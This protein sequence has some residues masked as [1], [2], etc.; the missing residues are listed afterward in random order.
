MASKVIMDQWQKR[1]ISSEQAK[2]DLIR[3]RCRGA[4]NSLALIEALD[5]RAEELE[6]QEKVGAVL[7]KLERSLGSFRS[8]AQVDA[9]LAERE[10]HAATV[11]FRSRSLLLRGKSKSGKS[12]KALSLFGYKK[13]LLVNCQGLDTGLPSLRPFLHAHHQAIVFDEISE[14]QVL[15]NKMV[16]QC[17]PWPVQLSQ[18]VC[19]QHAYE[20]WFYG[21]ALI[22]C[23]NKFAMSKAEGLDE[24]EE[25]WLRSNVVDCWLPAGEAW[26]IPTPKIVP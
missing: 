16:F 7:D 23:S 24:E 19:N 13:T 4:S 15:H 11:H 22:L 5:K 20:R 21:C 26:Y 10:E 9:W 2:E 3:S 8:H 25:D 12:Q 14:Q 6:L 1:K 18:S 17:G